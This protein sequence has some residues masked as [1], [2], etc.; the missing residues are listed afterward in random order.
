MYNLIKA[1]DVKDLTFEERNEIDRV[2]DKYIRPMYYDYSQPDGAVDLRK[3]MEEIREMEDSKY[4]SI[5]TVEGLREMFKA[6]A[7]D[8]KMAAHSVVSA[9]PDDLL[10]SRILEDYDLESSPRIEE[11]IRQFD[12]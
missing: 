7:N 5:T 1:D 10:S 2:Y 3:A 8:I 9:N 12:L 11:I 4:K 6:D